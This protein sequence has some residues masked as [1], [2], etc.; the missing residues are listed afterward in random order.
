MKFL[1]DTNFLVLPAQFGVDV[2]ELLKEFGKPELFTL[3]LCLDELKKTPFERLAKQLI[4][5]KGVRIEDT[6]EGTPADFEL[7]RIAKEKKMA[8]CTQD[9]ELITRLKL[10][11]VPVITLRQNRY[12]IR[13]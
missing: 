2:F 4:K 7:C 13:L 6:R 5:E 3:N 11:K 10:D 1:L 12:L 8:V 9:R